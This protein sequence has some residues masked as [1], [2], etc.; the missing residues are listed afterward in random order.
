MTL[1]LSED[2]F[3]SLHPFSCVVD[4]D[5]RAIIIGRSLLKL[6]PNLEPGEKIF[7]HLTLVHPALEDEQVALEALGGELILLQGNHSGRLKLRGHIVH[8]PAQPKRYL[9]ALQPAA[10][11][12]RE[13]A[14]NGLNFSDFALGDPVFDF[15][16]LVRQLEIANERLDSLVTELE[17]DRRYSGLLCE[18]AND[19]FLQESEAE[20]YRRTLLLVC[21]RLGWNCGRVLVT[22]TNTSGQV[23]KPISYGTDTFLLQNP[24]LHF[25]LSLSED[26]RVLWISEF[27][28]SNDCAT[29]AAPAGTRSYQVVWIPIIVAGQRISTLVF[30]GDSR[31]QYSRSYK[32]FF[33][34]LGHQVAQAI[35]HVR[36]REAETKR[37]AAMAHAAKM[38]TLGQIAAGVAHEINN[39]VSTASLIA[40]LLKRSVTSGTVSAEFVDT[41]VNRLELCMQRITKIVSELRGFSRD[42]V[43]DPFRLE[44]LQ[45]I[46]TETLDLCS[47]GFGLKN[48]SLICDEVS[49][50]WRVW[51]RASQISQVLLNLLCN[52]QD[53]VCDCEERWVRIEVSEREA[54]YE[55]SVSDSG[56]GVPE[57]IRD[58]VMTPFFTTKG[59]GHGTGLGLSI[60]ANIMVDH[61]GVLYLDDEA[62]TTRFV[63]RIPKTPPPNVELADT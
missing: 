40:A 6:I 29:A 45:T 2:L 19:L 55:I 1:A 21:E 3:Q 41:Q 50:N 62:S 46:F 22:G 37:I 18:L 54:D 53:A 47:A 32:Q 51:C 13:L 15:I 33:E 8:M 63:V 56:P 60:S 30:L 44:S 42:A 25:Q 11:C 34:L 9:F 27:D 57:A 24:Q 7:E 23:G 61:G 36:A 12:A 39:P 28:V 52:A 4:E 17:L 59:P 5:E 14:E 43:R 10:G 35:A 49:P 38:A 20:M 31:Q 16:L 26:S 58:K 48:I